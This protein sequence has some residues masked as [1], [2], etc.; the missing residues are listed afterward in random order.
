MG[1]IT[2]PEEIAAYK[3]KMS[4]QQDSLNARM[5]E[6]NYAGEQPVEAHH[7]EGETG[8]VAPEEGEMQMH[9]EEAQNPESYQPYHPEEHMQQDFVGDV[10]QDLHHGDEGV[11][12]HH[13]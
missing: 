10:P 11:E 4:E 12:V 2:N 5:I 13:E 9:H 1:I 6:S 7:E 8:H 3:M